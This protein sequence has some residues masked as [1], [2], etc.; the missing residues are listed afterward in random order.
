M[1][2]GP[3]TSLHQATELS[4]SEGTSLTILK[5]GIAVVVNC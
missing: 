4:P 3:L 5:G 1:Y 2:D